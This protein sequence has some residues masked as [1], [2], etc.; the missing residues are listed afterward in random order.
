[1]PL[2]TDGECAQF[3]AELT[4]H[5]G[6]G[7]LTRMIHARFPNH[8]D[9]DRFLAWS[10]DHT[11]ALAPPKARLPRDLLYR[12]VHNTDF[13]DDDSREN[14]ED[15][16]LRDDLPAIPLG[17]N[18]AGSYFRLVPHPFKLLP[19]QHGKPAFSDHPMFLSLAM[20]AITPSHLHRPTAEG[21]AHSIFSRSASASSTSSIVVSSSSSG[22]SSGNSN[23]SIEDAR[24]FFFHQ[25][26]AI[27]FLPA[28]SLPT[29]DNNKWEPTGFILV[30]RINHATGRSGPDGLYAILDAFP[31][32]DEVLD[33]GRRREDALPEYQKQSACRALVGEDA[34]S[35]SCAWLG[36]ETA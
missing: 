9:C 23:T 35:F 15:L 27:E 34:A 28:T 19:S 32:E 31:V 14:L 3:S 10:H 16:L 11:R 6:T 13:L 12:R 2:P 8:E 1:M 25:L 20:M 24:V 18:A 7:D 29:E 30:T 33:W 21:N 4:R 36:G 5:A 17:H 26:G 22:S